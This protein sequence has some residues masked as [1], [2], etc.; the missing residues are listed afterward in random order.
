MF[1]ILLFLLVLTTVFSYDKKWEEYMGKTQWYSFAEALEHAKRREL[2]VLGFY[3]GLECNLCHNYLKMFSYHPKFREVSKKFILAALDET[4]PY[5][6]MDPI[7]VEHY[8]PKFVFFDSNGKL[9]D[10]TNENNPDQKYFYSNIES[11]LNAMEEVDDYLYDMK[12]DL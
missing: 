5:Y 1:A 9:L 7:D 12:H 2:P 8:T 6:N 10:F 3:I 4:D 11:I